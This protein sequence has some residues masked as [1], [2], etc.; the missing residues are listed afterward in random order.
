MKKFVLFVL[1][2]ALLFALASCAAT[3][4][5]SQVAQPPDEATVA[6]PDP[7]P[8]PAP[9][10]PAPTPT[11]FGEAPDS[12]GENGILFDIYPQRAEVD[13]NLDGM[14]ERIEFAAGEEA[15]TLYI[16]GTAY[17]IEYAALAQCFAV[18]D[19]DT[20]DSILELGFTDKYY[21]MADS[22]EAY[23]YLFWWDGEQLYDMGPAAG[24]KFDGPWRAELHPADFFDG[25]GL[26][27]YVTR[28]SEFTDVWYMGHFL[29]DGAERALKEDFYAADPLYE[30]DE[31]SLK[32]YCV[33]LKKIDSAYF[34]SEYS[35]IW[36]YASGYATLPRDH[37]DEI[38]AFI[39]QEG[40][41]LRI[42]RVYGQYWFKL[43][44]DDGKTGWLKCVEG[45]IQGIYQ[46]MRWDAFDIF[47][48]IVIAG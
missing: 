14:A 34:D 36:D 10:T 17:P 3:P 20:A 45:K 28:T 24:L 29:C 33:L 48:G 26:V 13:I 39:P 16:N 21:E 37:S 40:E 2:A 6:A 41:V 27:Q 11:P 42:V 4:E 31:L 35:V 25:Q 46:V 38:V 18:T 19:I 8:S 7:S 43:E 30:P 22:E 12:A 23:T 47:D 5:P 9:P 32:T 1:T 15:S 44:A